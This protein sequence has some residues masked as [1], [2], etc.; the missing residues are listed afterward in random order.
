MR[1]SPFIPTVTLIDAKRLQ[2]LGFPQDRSPQLVYMG[3]KN[4]G[5]VDGFFPGLYAATDEWRLNIL[6]RRREARRRTPDNEERYAA[7]DVLTALEWLEAERGW[8]WSRGNA[9]WFA[10]QGDHWLPEDA[11][12]KALAELTTPQGFATSEELL[13]AILAALIAQEA[14]HA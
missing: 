12:N 8:R 7:P 13:G 11:V 5:G 4:A 14:A 1:S 9:G 2:V 6:E 3:P 10:H